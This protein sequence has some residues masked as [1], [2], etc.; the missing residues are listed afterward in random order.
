MSITLFSPS[1]PYN[2]PEEIL[3]KSL[4]I[5]C[6]PENA[7]AFVIAVLNKN[8]SQRL[9]AAE[10]LQHP[11]LKDGDK[12]GAVEVPGAIGEDDVAGDKVN[13]FLVPDAVSTAAFE[14]MQQARE[15]CTDDEN[16]RR[17]RAIKKLQE[18]AEKKK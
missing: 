9:S 6:V 7:R 14:L 13:E 16:K 12:V 11:F 2:E 18:K 8:F 15:K 5:Q 3:H 17:Q 10:C 1:F 4:D